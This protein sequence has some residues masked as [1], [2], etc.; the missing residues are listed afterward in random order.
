[1]SEVLSQLHFKDEGKASYSG[2]AYRGISEAFPNAVV[3]D[4]GESRGI[5][6]DARP[7]PKPHYALVSIGAALIVDGRILLGTQLDELLNLSNRCGNYQQSSIEAVKLPVQETFPGNSV[8]DVAL[9]GFGTKKTGNDKYQAVCEGILLN[10]DHSTRA[11][12]GK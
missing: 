9:I 5:Y 8:G 6:H 11:P 2:V 12:S 1:M 3:A 10:A 7:P 4:F